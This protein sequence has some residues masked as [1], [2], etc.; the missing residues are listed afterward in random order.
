MPG[1]SRHGKKE[2]KKW[3]NNHYIST[4]LDIGCGQATYPKLLGNKYTYYG[5]EIWTPYIKKFDLL[6]YYKEIF[7]GDVLKLKLIVTDCIILGDILEH[8]EKEQAKLLLQKALVEY[9]HVVLSIPLSDTKP[10]EGAIRYQNPYEKHISYWFFDE[11]KKFTNWDYAKN[12]RDIGIFC[13]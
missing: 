6:D 7:I 4:I 2:I 3:I 1:S 8:L 12:I 5:V 9:Q 13:R 11:L 10:Y